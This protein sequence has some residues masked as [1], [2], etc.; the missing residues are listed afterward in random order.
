MFIVWRMDRR[1]LHFVLLMLESSDQ[2]LHSVRV[3]LV[4]AELGLVVAELVPVPKLAPVPTFALAVVHSMYPDWMDL[5]VVVL[6]LEQELA[7]DL[8]APEFRA[9]VVDAIELEGI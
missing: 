5:V 3:V 4:L 6:E 1:L 7:A 9:E 2:V 8:A